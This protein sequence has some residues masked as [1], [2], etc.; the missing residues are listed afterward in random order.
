MYLSV[1][2]NPMRNGRIMAGSYQKVH[3]RRPPPDGGRRRPAG[4]EFQTCGGRHTGHDAGEIPVV[5]AHSLDRTT[6]LARAPDVCGVARRAAHGGRAGAAA[7][8]V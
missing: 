6:R 3:E 4:P 5:S 1:V 7:A 2:A 8:R